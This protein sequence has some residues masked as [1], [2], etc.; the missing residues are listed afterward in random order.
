[1]KNLELIGKHVDV[2]A[3]KERLEVSG[4]SPLPTA[5]PPPGAASKS[6]LVVKNDSR[7]HVAG[8]AA[9][10]DIAS[11]R[12]TRWAMRCMR[13]RGARMAQSWRT[14]PGREVAG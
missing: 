7:S 4:T 11:S 5:W 14:P 9:V 3:F 6:R 10:E 2:N 1:V 12:M 13:S 8:R